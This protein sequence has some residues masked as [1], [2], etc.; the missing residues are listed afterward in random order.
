MVFAGLYEWWRDPAAADD[1]PDKWMLST[2]ILTREATGELLGIHDR[3]PV[4]LSPELLDE[5]LDPHTEGSDELLEEISAGGAEVAE[6]A[7]FHEV[8]GAVGNVRS[9]GPSLIA[10]VH[11]A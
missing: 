6:Y 1:S 11:A 9:S 5:W 10:P 2:S 7:E 8:D 4:F 3:M